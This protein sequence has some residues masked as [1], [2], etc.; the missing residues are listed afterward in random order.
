[1]WLV[2]PHKVTALGKRQAGRE[3]QSQ[4]ELTFL[5]KA[6]GASVVHLQFFLRSSDLIAQVSGEV[7]S[8][9]YETTLL[10]HL[11]HTILR[12]LH[13]ISTNII[14]LYVELLL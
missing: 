7:C 10:D 3:K 1:M 9:Y 4:E 14:R 8:R 2:C 13:K 6:T 11:G 12:E 5:T